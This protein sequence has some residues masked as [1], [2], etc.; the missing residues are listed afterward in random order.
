[1]ASSGQAVD[2]VSWSG[3][4]DSFLAWL[5][6]R[7]EAL[8][9]AVLLTTHDADSETIAH[10]ELPISTIEA[11]AQALAVDLI[12]V[13]LHPSVAYEDA[14]ELALDMVA[15]RFS[16]QRLVFGDLHL[17]EIRDWRV[18]TFS[19]WLQRNDAA[20]HF[21]LWHADPAALLQRLNASGARATLS[22]TPGG[23]GTVGQRF[24][25]AFMASLPPQVDAFGENG[26]FHTRVEPDS[27]RPCGP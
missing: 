6:L 9:P 2:V 21:P 3:G 20:L 17:E 4:K 23:Y 14:I 7:D 16:V 11:Q 27:L 24:D 19:P 12:A 1:V 5:S 26:E 22:A 10:Q 15:A 25:A 18:R 13:P 8:R